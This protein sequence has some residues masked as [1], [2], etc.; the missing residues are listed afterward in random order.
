[1]SLRKASAMS[2]LDRAVS[3]RADAQPHVFDRLLAAGRPLVMGV[4][5][6]TPDSFSDGG[7]FIDPEIAIA[8]ARRMAAEGADILDVGAESTRPYGGAVPVSLEDEFARLE[9]VLAAV[10]D[11]GIP[12]SIDTIKAEVAGWALRLGAAIVNDV[13]GL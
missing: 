7:R 8:H 12:V 13:W 9:P 1:L 2:P 5:N 3:G 10:V 4:L 11:L 6:V